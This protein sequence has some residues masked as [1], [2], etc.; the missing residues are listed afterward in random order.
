MFEFRLP[1]LGE[2]IHEGEVL[3]WHVNPGD[4][5]VEDAPLVDVE[6]DKAAV[7][8]PSPRSGVVVSTTGKVGDI[9]KTGQVLA[10]IDVAGAE[11][12]ARAGTGAGAGTGV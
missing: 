6:T 12:G 11:V 3:K 1:D 2:G 8:I 10:V 9:V 5:I 7:T 4:K